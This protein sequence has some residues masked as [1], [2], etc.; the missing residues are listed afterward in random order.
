MSD[1]KRLVSYIYSYPGGARDKNVGFAKAEVRAGQLKLSVSLKGVY[2]DAPETF[3]VY[4]MVDRDAQT[5]GRFTLLRIGNVIVNAG[6]G[7]YADLL[8]P[9][10]INGSGYEFSDISGIAVARTDD[11]Y[12]M[13]FS[14][15]EDG[16]VSP[17]S[18]IFAPD[19]HKKNAEAVV[20]ETAEPVQAEPVVEPVV[21]PV[22]A[23]EK[24]PADPPLKAEPLQAEPEP[25]PMQESFMAAK[26]QDDAGT[27]PKE[28]VEN[29]SAPVIPADLP[30]F[31]KREPVP[32]ESPKAAPDDVQ[33]TAAAQQQMRQMR[34][35]GMRP[36]NPM[37][38]GRKMTGGRPVG[39][40]PSMQ[41]RQAF[42]GPG[43]PS[44]RQNQQKPVQDGF[45]KVFQ[46]ADFI[47]AFDDDYYYDCV[48]VSP[49]VL[50]TLPIE[51]EAI[52]NNSFLV[53]GYYNFKHILFG[54]VREN[55]NNTR[56]FIGVPGMYCNR[57]R[58]MASMFGF[59]NFKKSHRSDYTNPYFGYW[60]QEI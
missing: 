44:A 56:Y 17:E 60:Y 10:N 51:D 14:L 22:V 25:E 3:G 20:P 35:Q 54:R 46:Q 21:A 24:L 4:L 57:E 29:E 31:V 49:E 59:N 39:V 41:Q 37:Q 2:T 36:Q 53:H 12:Y 34:N 16:V 45:S 50:K 28:T 15:W 7:T 48:E 6:V 8:N 55:D 58:F 40:Q 26:E 43:M 42:R 11:R 1:Y 13:M 47:D 52:I 32:Q 33:A 18:V 30:E 9:G 38:Q 23:P 19:T 27:N 5:E